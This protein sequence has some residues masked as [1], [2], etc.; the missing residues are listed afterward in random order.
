MSNRSP[1]V[2][3]L[4]ALMAVLAVAAPVAASWALGDG[5]VCCCGP[6]PDVSVGIDDC[7]CEVDRPV[8]APPGEPLTGTQTV[9]EWQPAARVSS[10]LLAVTGTTSVVCRD[11]AQP[12]RAR[13]PPRLM[14][15][16]L[17]L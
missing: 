12:L 2:V 4:F 14:H 8:E 15:C 5:E 6:R 7:G 16:V 10:G 1:L 3:A 9:V 13:P 17:T 11:S